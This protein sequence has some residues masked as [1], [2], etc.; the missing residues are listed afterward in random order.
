MTVRGGWLLR[1]AK[2]GALRSV[3]SENKVFKSK[4][5]SMLTMKGVSK[6]RSAALKRLADR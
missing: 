1:D 4:A 5:D 3:G 2:T 6:R